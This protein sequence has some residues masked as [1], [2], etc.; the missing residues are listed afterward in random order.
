MKV[1]ENVRKS[2]DGAERPTAT[3]N[4]GK[5]FSSRASPFCPGLA[6]MRLPVKRMSNR[7]IECHGGADHASKDKH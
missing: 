5:L 2:L 7:R 4:F 1:G 3:G 6:I